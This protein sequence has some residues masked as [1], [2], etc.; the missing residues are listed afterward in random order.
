MKCKYSRNSRGNVQ[1]FGGMGRAPHAPYP[2]KSESYPTRNA[3]PA[4]NRVPSC[5]LAIPICG[6]SGDCYNSM[7]NLTIQ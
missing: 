7:L 1:I 4:R 2:Q 3:V 5:T 6:S